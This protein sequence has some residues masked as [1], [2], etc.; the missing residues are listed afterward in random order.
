MSIFNNLIHKICIYL[1]Q[2]NIE[3]DI[4]YKF[5]F[6]LDHRLCILVCN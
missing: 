6:E 2:E 1:S 3:A 4:R 5:L